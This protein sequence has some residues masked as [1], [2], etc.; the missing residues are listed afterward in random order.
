MK[1]PSQSKTGPRR[2]RRGGGSPPSSP[3]CPGGEDSDDYLM[4]VSLVEAAGTGGAS[5]QKGDWHQ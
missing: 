3:E 5:G 4:P 2:R 1:M